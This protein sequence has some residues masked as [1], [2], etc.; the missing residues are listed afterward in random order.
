MK[1]KRK[2]KRGNPRGLEPPADIVSAHAA[3]GYV[4]PAAA[5]LAHGLNLKTIYA[6]MAKWKATAERPF[7]HLVD[8]KVAAKKDGPNVWV[9]LAAV[10]QQVAAR[11]G[12]AV[13]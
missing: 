9:L 3:D 5:A 7:G 6:W 2:A 13:A 1:T 4:T 10:D 8:G 11:R 12:K